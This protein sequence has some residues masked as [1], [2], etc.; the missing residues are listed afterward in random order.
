M[1]PF[2]NNLPNEQ[3]FDDEEDL[4]N[5]SPNEQH[6]DDEKHLYVKAFVVA[7]PVEFVET[8]FLKGPKGEIYRKLLRMQARVY[9][10]FFKNKEKVICNPISPSFFTGLMCNLPAIGFSTEDQILCTNIGASFFF[11]ISSHT[12]DRN[13][14]SSTDLS[15]FSRFFI[16]PYAS[17]LDSEFDLNTGEKKG[18]KTYSFVLEKYEISKFFRS[19][20]WKF[21]YELFSSELMNFN[22][23]DAEY[24]HII[25]K[26]YFFD[27]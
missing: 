26:N 19:P 4:Q 22:F 21:N 20:H 7:V 5:N 10:N 17:H 3:H 13:Y 14:V 27:Y 9:A 8:Q 2:Q 6:I 1:I 16:Y 11:F 25:Y 18:K 15:L 24:V 12:D 23:K